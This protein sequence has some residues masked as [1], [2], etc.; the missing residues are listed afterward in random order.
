MLYEV[1]AVTTEQRLHL[2]EQGPLSPVR[3]E[4]P[5]GGIGNDPP[6]LEITALI[7]T[8]A[9]GVFIETGIA[10]R[11]GLKAIG[12][13]QVSSVTD[14]FDPDPV[15]RVKLTINESFYLKME[16]IEMPRSADRYS[17]LIG[18]SLLKHAQFTYDG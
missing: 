10:Q 8:G 1:S 14:R 17:C 11:L 6:P 2:V 15:Y 12:T 3:R 5:A 7:D 16:A 13:R 4:R 18:R 9:S